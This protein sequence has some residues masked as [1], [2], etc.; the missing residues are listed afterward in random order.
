MSRGF[1]LTYSL[2]TRQADVLLRQLPRGTT[3]AR[4][5]GTETPWLLN[6][7]WFLDGD[8]PAPQVA[9]PFASHDVLLDVRVE[10]GHAPTFRVVCRRDASR[11]FAPISQG[12]PPSPRQGLT[13]P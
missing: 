5:F 13:T 12:V 7:R 9:G 6:E 10:E 3:P 2:R 1:T 8:I 4:P 11:V